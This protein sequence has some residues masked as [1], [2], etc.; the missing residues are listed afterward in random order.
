MLPP[1]SK[2][3][4]YYNLILKGTMSLK[5]EVLQ[6]TNLAILFHRHH[7]KAAK[8]IFRGTDIKNSPFASSP[9]MITPVS[10][11]PYVIT[12]KIKTITLL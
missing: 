9:E 5:E 8:S 1:Y 2:V 3:H 4:L 7:A 6:P 10:C 11:A 12:T